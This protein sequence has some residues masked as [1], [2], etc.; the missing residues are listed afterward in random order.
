MR[1]RVRREGPPHPRLSR[2]PTATRSEGPVAKLASNES[3]VPADPRGRRGGHQGARAA[4]NR[5]PDPTNA[6]LRTRALGPLRRAR[7]PHRDR[8]RLV[9][10]PARRRRRA[11][12]A[13]RRG[14]LRVAELLGLPAPRGRL[15]R[16]RDRGP[17]STPST[18]TTSTRCARRSPSPTRLV[19]RL[20]PEQ[21]DVDRAAARARSPPS[22]TTCRRHVAVILDEAYCEFNI[23]QDP[24]ESIDLLKQAPEP[25]AAAHVLEGLRP[26]RPARRLRAVRLGGRSAPPSTR[27]A[28]RS[29]ATPPP[30]PRRSRRSATRTRSPAAS[31]ATSPSGSGSRTGCAGS[32]SSPPSRRPTS[33]GSTSPR[34][35]DPPRPSARSSRASPQR[36]ILVRAG[37][38]ARAA[39]ARC[40]SRSAPRPRTSASSTRS[41]HCSEARTCRS[42]TLQ[43]RTAR[44]HRIAAYSCAGAAMPFRLAISLGAR[45]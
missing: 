17:A 23:L 24:D 30:R 31:S 5:Y 6:A 10:H 27:S 42:M 12:R 40:A 19:D 22:S 26:L 34:G 8:Q 18:S 20:Q 4:L 9:R 13:R 41:A 38:V 33:S 39:R 15:R 37:G 29:S 35:D 32:A 16:P 7:Q 45:P 3:P 2:P 11:A 21:P 43:H 36:G 14:R 25:R 1:A 44:A 28:S